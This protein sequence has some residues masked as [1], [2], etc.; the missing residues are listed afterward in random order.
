VLSEHLFQF[1]AAYFLFHDSLF[2]G[3]PPGPCSLQRLLL[4]DL[5]KFNTY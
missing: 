5:E 4:Q 3:E 2:H 1:L